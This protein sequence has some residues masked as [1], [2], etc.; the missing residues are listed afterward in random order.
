MALTNDTMRHENI[1]GGQTA[2]AEDFLLGDHD[3]RNRTEEISTTNGR[4]IV[5]VVD[6]VECITY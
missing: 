5:R 6:V 3:Q 1:G 2:E 4:A